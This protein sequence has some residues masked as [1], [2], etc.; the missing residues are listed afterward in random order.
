ME[1]RDDSRTNGI[2][3]GLSVSQAQ[4]IQ[5]NSMQVQ[6]EHLLYALEYVGH[7]DA[8]MSKIHSLPLR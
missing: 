5:N 3:G 2:R 6:P 8:K 4:L 7:C 1:R